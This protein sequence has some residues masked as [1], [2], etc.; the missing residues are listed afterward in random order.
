MRN[1]MKYY[2][3]AFYKAKYGDGKY[4]DDA[5]SIYTTLVNVIG[6]SVRLKLKLAWKCLKNRYSHVEVWRPDEDGNFAVPYTCNEMLAGDK[7]SWNRYT[8]TCFTST[9]RS[10]NNGTV[11]RPAQGILGKHPERW[12]VTEAI[13]CDDRKYAAAMEWSQWQADHNAGYNKATIANM[14]NPFRKTVISNNPLDTPPVRKN[15]CSVAAQGFCWMSGL[16]DKWYIWS[17]LKLAYKLW[18]KGI[19][20]KPLKE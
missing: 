16:F 9:M 8:G 14:F 6:L 20:I 7:T 12:D 11:V 17:P 10:D 5:I 1:E 19:E 3:L 18:E 15:I 4:I 13:E 2:K